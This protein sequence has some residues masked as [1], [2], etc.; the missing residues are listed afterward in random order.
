MIFEYRLAPSLR[1]CGMFVLPCVWIMR[2]SGSTFSTADGRT[3]ASVPPGASALYATFCVFAS[4]TASKTSLI[5]ADA[6]FVTSARRASSERLRSRT[7]VAPW[8][9][10][11]S[12]LRREAVVTMGP[13]PASLDSWM[14]M[15]R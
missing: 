4:E 12:A 15:K 9:F 1:F 6:I 13:K 10:R 3:I 11:L 8:R 2:F 7:C 14:T 5:G